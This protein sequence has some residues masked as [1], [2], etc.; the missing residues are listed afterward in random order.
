MLS[1]V[2]I[3]ASFM[4]EVIPMGH[5]LHDNMRCL[6][7][8][9]LIIGILSLGSTKAMS[10][11]GRLR[12]LVTEHAELFVQLYPDRVKPKFHHLFHI[13]DN[14]VWLGAL[15]SCFVCERKHRSTKRAALW[16]FRSVDNT[17][18]KEMLSRQCTA[19]ADDGTSLFQKQWLH[20]PKAL[21]FGGVSLHRSVRACLECG[22]INAGDLLW[23]QSGSSAYVGRAIAFWECPQSKQ[24]SVQFSRYTRV[25]AHG[26]RWSSANSDVVFTSTDHIVDAM[27]YADMGGDIFLVIQPCTPQL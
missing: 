20:A 24:I 12:T 2:P 1:L 23:L 13:A 6:W 5:A 14:M 10:Y 4:A 15:A 11:V 21:I 26:T 19:I 7:R 9:H 18:V 17:V 27:T 16:V 25:D 3:V 22:P 8:L